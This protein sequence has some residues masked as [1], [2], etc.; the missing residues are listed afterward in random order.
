VKLSISLANHSWPDGPGSIGPRVAKLVQLADQA[1]FDTLW[2]MDHMFQIPIN[3]PS[4][5]P[6]L[7]AYAL[8]GFTAGHTERIRLG[9]LVTAVSYRHP[10]LL[11]KTLTAL[12]VLSQGRVWLGIGAAWHEEE[13]RAFGLPFPPRAERYERLEETLQLAHRMW[14][15]DATAF[16][17]KHYR[18]ENPYN[19]PNSVQQPHPPILVGGSGE[20]K[21]LRL[22][23]QYADACNLFDLP[24]GVEVAGIRGGPV[25]LRHKL[26]VLRDHCEAV[27]RPYGDIEKTIT[28]TFAITAD[29]TGG[30]DG[31]RGPAEIVD[32]FGSLAEL[33]LEHVFFEPTR[34]WDEASLE[35]MAAIIPELEGLS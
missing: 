4:T 16:E 6:L 31:A 17:G 5:D 22:V 32:H 30:A 28:S 10:G 8:L 18:L 34:P 25:A 35:L 2:A 12:D 3:G 19:C 27:G 14:A 24:E 11:I 9:A 23:A 21:T 15:G 1:G 20:R 29:G 26:D 7:E 13:A 33:G